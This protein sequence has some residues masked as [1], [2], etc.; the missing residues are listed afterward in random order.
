MKVE[1]AELTPGMYFA[2]DIE[3]KIEKVFYNQKEAESYVNAKNKKVKA[4][5]KNAKGK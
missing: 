3:H 1:E 5:I 4:F 2:K